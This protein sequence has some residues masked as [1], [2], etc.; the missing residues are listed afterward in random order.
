MLML[1]LNATHGCGI[2]EDMILEEFIASLA[3]NQIVMW[4]SLE[5]LLSPL[6]APNYKIGPRS[7]SPLD[8]G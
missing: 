5:R 6:V 4:P 1:C 3:S 7:D 8:G 2:I